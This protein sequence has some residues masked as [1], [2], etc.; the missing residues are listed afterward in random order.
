MA[1]QLK[2]ILRAYSGIGNPV[3]GDR[4]VTQV[5]TFKVDQLYINKTDGSVWIRKAVNGVAADW[6]TLEVSE[7]G[8]GGGESLIQEV[9]VVLNDT[10]IKDLQNGTEIIPAPGVGKAIVLVAGFV[11]SEII[12]DGYS[13]IDVSCVLLHAIGKYRTNILKLQQILGQNDRVGW[14]QIPY[15]ALGTG[16]FDGEIVSPDNINSDPV[17]NKALLI[18]DEWSGGGAAT[19]GNAANKLH[20]TVYY[21][22]A[23]V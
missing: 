4:L 9:T 3:D 18:Q 21:I 20:V 6:E 11:R 16:A 17:E 15:L 8:G 7:G 1:T 2:N 10:Q 23:D 5:T 13:A 14:F 12:G 19:G 22:I